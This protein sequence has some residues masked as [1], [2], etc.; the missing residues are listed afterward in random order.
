MKRKVWIIEN[1]KTLKA[2]SFGDFVYAYECFEL[3]MDVVGI[4]VPDL[5]I[6]FSCLESKFYENEYFIL[7]EVIIDKTEDNQHEE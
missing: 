5:E 1:K 4:S 2:K 7:K 3:L 6:F